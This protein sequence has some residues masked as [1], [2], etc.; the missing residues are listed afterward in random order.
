MLR[1][2]HSIQTNNN[3]SIFEEKQHSER[4]LNYSTLK[5]RFE[6]CPSLPLRRRFTRTY[7]YHRNRN[8]LLI[9]P[10][11]S[12]YLSSTLDIALKSVQKLMQAC[13]LR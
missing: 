5:L 7:T 6:N 2:W 11:L 12:T 8:R 9:L 1:H 13:D 4:L 3:K 10:N